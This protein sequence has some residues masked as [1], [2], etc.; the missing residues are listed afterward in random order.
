[1]LASNFTYLVNLANIRHRIVHDQADAKRKFEAATLQI[2][3]RTYS[4]SRPGK[5][6]RDWDTSKAP[7]QRWLEVTIAAL[8]ALTSQIV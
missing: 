1:M 7:R 8:I 2:A 4:S 6:L 5:F 3:A